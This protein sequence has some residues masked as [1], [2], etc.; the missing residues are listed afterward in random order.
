MDIQRAR[1][2]A[3]EAVAIGSIRHSLSCISSHC[4][5]RRLGL[6]RLHTRPDVEVLGV[7]FG[8]DGLRMS[9][10]VDLMGE[11]T[12]PRRRRLADIP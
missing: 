10:S 12:L 2:G 6:S 9:C 8:L 3:G 1:K 4:T 11:E 5:E 7:G